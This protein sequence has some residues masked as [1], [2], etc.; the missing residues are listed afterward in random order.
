MITEFVITQDGNGIFS[1]QG[2]LKAAVSSVE[3]YVHAGNF[4]F[5][6]EDEALE[7]E[8][9]DIKVIDEHREQILNLSQALIAYVEN[10]EI[11][12]AFEVPFI[13]IG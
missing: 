3:F 10:D 11:I 8:M 6:Y 5:N 1:C 9:L 4:V 7:Q 12:E 2:A 13:H